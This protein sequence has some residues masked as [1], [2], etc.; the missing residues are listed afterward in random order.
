MKMNLMLLKDSNGKRLMHFKSG[1]TK[2]M[3]DIN[4]EEVIIE[5]LN[6]LFRRIQ[7]CTFCGEDISDFAKICLS[8]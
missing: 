4:T 3:I 1:D 6:S 2:F 8:I 5:L 7:T